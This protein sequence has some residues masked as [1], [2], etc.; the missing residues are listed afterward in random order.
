MILPKTI[1]KWAGPC[2]PGPDL[3]R[4]LQVERRILA[5][6]PPSRYP[7]EV[8]LMQQSAPTRG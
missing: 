6:L 8:W 2:P 3:T 7:G 1:V 5:Q 4:R